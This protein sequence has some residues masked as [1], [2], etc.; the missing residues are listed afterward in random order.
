MV[1]REESESLVAKIS[2]NLAFL[3]ISYVNLARH[4]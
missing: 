4:I 2:E 3:R 1:E